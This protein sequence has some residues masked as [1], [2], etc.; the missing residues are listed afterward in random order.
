M[1]LRFLRDQTWPGLSRSRQDS[2][3]AQICYLGGNHGAGL[4]GPVTGPFVERLPED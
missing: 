4:L 3:K 1:V 2:T